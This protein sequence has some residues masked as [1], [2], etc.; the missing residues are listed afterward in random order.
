MI[1]QG[2]QAAASA[3]GI[4]ADSQKLDIAREQQKIAQ[5]NATSEEGY[6]KAQATALA[7]KDTSDHLDQKSVAELTS[8][9]WRKSDEPSEGAQAF[10]LKGGKQAYFT[11]PK[12]KVEKGADY[13]D[14]EA[15]DPKTGNNVLVSVAKNQPLP[16]GYLA[17]KKDATGGKATDGE[18]KFAAYGSRMLRAT[19]QAD[20]IEGSGYD[21][22]ATKQLLS[23]IPVAGNFMVSDVSRMYETTKR[24]FISAALREESGATITDSEFAAADKKYFPQPGDDPKTINYKAELRRHDAENFL[25]LGGKASEKMGGHSKSP[26]IPPSQPSW[27][28][29][30]GFEAGA[31][32]APQP[33]QPFS[34]KG[35]LEG[36]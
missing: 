10:T 31:A 13:R 22:S 34:P 14:V 15:Y 29:K 33:S 12:E 24:D 27:G 28:Q 2:L 18:A 5:Q 19:E 9:G 35:Y 36:R 7:A 32:P 26:L 4:Y 25:A 16:P 23:K 11:P 1:Q 3:Y 21:P 17:P 8:K 20:K 6:K 30:A